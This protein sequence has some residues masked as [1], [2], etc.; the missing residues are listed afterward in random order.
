M[1]STPSKQER[2]L[3][4]AIAIHIECSLKF[5]GLQARSRQ[6]HAGGEQR[7]L[8]IVPAVER[9]LDYFLGVDNSPSSGGFG[10]EQRRG[11]DYVHLLRRA[12]QLHSD[13]QPDAL[14]HLQDDS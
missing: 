1:L 14:I 12:A 8:I 7:E 6:K 10:F 3:K 13:I 4:S 9:Q 2:V 11:T 5:D